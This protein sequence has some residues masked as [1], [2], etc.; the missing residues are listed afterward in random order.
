MQASVW[1]MIKPGEDR[2]F[3]SPN[4]P[5]PEWAAGLRRDGYKIVRVDFVINPED[6]GSVFPDEVITRSDFNDELPIVAKVV[7]FSGE[8]GDGGHPDK[9]E[10]PGT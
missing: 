8:F 1:Y 10:Q 6:I 7:P 2:R 9:H 4:P 5:S 3:A